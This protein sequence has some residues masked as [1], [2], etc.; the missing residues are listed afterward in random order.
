MN[1]GNGSSSGHPWA[2]VPQAVIGESADIFRRLSRLPQ[3]WT[4]AQEVKKGATP[5]EVVYREDRMRLL[6][7]PADAPPKFKT[8]LVFVFALVNRP[9]ILDLLPGKSV[10]E[11]FVKAGFDTYLVDWG[12][13]SHADRFNTLRDY[14]D[15]YLVNVVEHVRQRTGAS[16]VSV[17][18][19]CMGGTMSAMFTALHPQSVKNL[20]L[21]A[22]GIDFSTCAGLLNLWSQPQYFDVDAFV[23]AWGNCPAAFLQTNFTLLKPV[24]NLVEKPLSLWERLDDDRFVDE[25]LTMETWLGDNIPVPGE[26]FRQFVK[27]LYQQNLLVQNR[28]RVGAGWSSCSGSP[29]RCSIS[30]PAATTWSPARRASLSTTWW[31]HRIGR[32]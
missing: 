20:I 9:Y 15:G 1:D 31:A 12:V 21:L 30:W 3:L 26:T 27:D 32:P 4:R 23:D 25:F 22:A 29:A 24:A 13:P 6:H 7:Y 2:G 11:H 28:L 18:G 17:L 5:S 10:V 8:P 14:I 16:Q 19:Y